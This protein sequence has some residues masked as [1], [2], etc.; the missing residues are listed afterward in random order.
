M[1]TANRVKQLER[2]KVGKPSFVVGYQRDDGTL[3][4]VAEW[5]GSGRVIDVDAMPKEA[6]IFRVVYVDGRAT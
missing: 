5:A 2:R 4:T 1:K 3:R 6:L